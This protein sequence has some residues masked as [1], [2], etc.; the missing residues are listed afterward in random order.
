MGTAQQIHQGREGCTP[1]DP[2]KGALQ[3]IQGREGCT[4]VDPGLGRVHSSRSRVGKAALQQIQGREGCTSAD[5]GQGRVYHS[6]S[7]AGE[8]A[9]QQIQGREGCTPTDPGLG[10]MPVP[11]LGDLNPLREHF[12]KSFAQAA[13]RLQ[14]LTDPGSG[15]APHSTGSLQQFWGCVSVA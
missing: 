13:K 1:A 12:K 5:P 10:S 7:R 14:G 11:S 15:S 8:G 9:P 6:W 3:L 2:G 4:Q